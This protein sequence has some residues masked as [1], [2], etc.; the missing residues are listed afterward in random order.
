MDR[1]RPIIANFDIDPRRATR[2]DLTLPGEF[3]TEAG[4]TSCIVTD[5]SCTGARVTGDLGLA[6]GDTGILKCDELDILTEVRWYA[7]DT[8][9]LSFAES[10]HDDSEPDI[11]S[12][13]ERFEEVHRRANNRRFLRLFWNLG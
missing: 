13:A 7:E 8:F 10:L 3:V 5:I 4:A 2:L 6:E 1:G 9:G 11:A 12:D